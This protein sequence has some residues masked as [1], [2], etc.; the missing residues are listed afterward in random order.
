MVPLA[1]EDWVD[2][3]AA[4]MNACKALGRKPKKS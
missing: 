4:Y 1:D 3:G 2:L